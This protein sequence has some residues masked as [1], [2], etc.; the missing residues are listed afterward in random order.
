MKRI[1]TRRAFFADVGR[2][3][4]VAT[5]GSAI[6]TELGL[7]RAFADA[8]DALVFGDLESLVCLMQETPANKLLPKLTDKLKSG[9]DLRRLVAAAALANARTFGGED[10]VGFHT[11]MALSPALHMARELPAEQ[12]ALPVFKV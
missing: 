4:I 3:M 9:T 11:M 1:E 10:Y 7:A 5:V 12:Q 2:G 8:P 6:A